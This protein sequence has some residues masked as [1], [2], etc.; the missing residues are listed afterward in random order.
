MLRN[1]QKLFEDAIKLTQMH[2]VNDLLCKTSDGCQKSDFIVV[3]LQPNSCQ[4]LN[5]WF[6][7]CSWST[8]KW[9]LS[10]SWVRITHT[11][12]HTQPQCFLIQW[13]TLC[14]SPQTV[15]T[16]RLYTWC[17]GPA[18]ANRSVLLLSA[19]RPSGTPAFQE[20]G[21]TSAWSILVVGL[22]FCFLV[23]SEALW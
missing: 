12:T 16:T 9:A 11:H 1:E 21:S 7:Y 18:T 22:L 3:N 13:L 8:Y 10:Q 5:Q 23:Q 2:R 19:T 14:C 17:P 15:W 4:V 20:P 6:S